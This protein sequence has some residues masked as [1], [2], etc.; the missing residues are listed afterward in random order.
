MTQPLLSLGALKRA[1]SPQRLEGYRQDPDRSDH[2]ALSCYLWNMAL[3]SALQPALHVLEITLRNSIYEAS[4]KVI[5]TTRLRMLD[6]Q[7]WLDARPSLLYVKEA[8]GVQKAK[9][10]LGSD[11]DRRTPGHLIGKLGFGFWVQLCAR[12]YNDLRADGPKL[13]PAALPIA[14]P[15]RFPAK[16]NPSHPEREVLYNRLHEIRKLRNKAAHH[17][18]IWDRD[19]QSGYD[20]VIETI[21][22]MN[23]SVASATAATNPFPAV[24]D[25]GPSA[26]REL[27]EKLLGEEP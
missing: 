10:Y 19:L 5:D 11:P 21:G 23:P 2:D 3:A 13:W 4:L 17:E 24:F 9:T 18:P 27:A 1:L 22:W 6:V 15:Y 25:S 12:V 16:S 14:F 20:N 8:E 26:Y 7:C